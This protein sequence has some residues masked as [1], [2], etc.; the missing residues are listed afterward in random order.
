MARLP[1]QTPIPARRSIPERL[2]P[3]LRTGDYVVVRIIAL[4]CVYSLAQGGHV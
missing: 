3:W 4:L 1:D 2:P